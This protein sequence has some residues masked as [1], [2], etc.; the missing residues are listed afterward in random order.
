MLGFYYDLLILMSALTLWISASQLTHKTQLQSEDTSK[1]S[2][3]LW[4]ILYKDYKHIKTLAEMINNAI[5]LNITCFLLTS[6]VDYA[7]SFDQL[8]SGGSSFSSHWSRVSTL[9]FYFGS[10]CGILLVSADI[11]RQV[12]KYITHFAN[13]ML[14]TFIFIFLCFLG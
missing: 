6:I 5:G 8:V 1:T 2:I 14:Y 10:A 3:L 13:Q 4:K 12:N 9:L 11:C 7:I